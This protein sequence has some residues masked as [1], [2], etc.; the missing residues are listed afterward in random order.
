MSYIFE[1]YQKNYTDVELI[2]IFNITSSPMV[3]GGSDCD[4]LSFPGNPYDLIIKN[5]R[6]MWHTKLNMYGWLIF[7]YPSKLMTITGYRIWAP[8]GCCTLQN[9]YLKGS[10]DG[11][12]WNQIAYVNSNTPIENRGK[13]AT[14]KVP[15]STYRMYKIEEEQSSFGS[16]CGTWFGLRKVDF[17]QIKSKK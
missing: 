10:N 16:N 6:S 9:H 4:G 2:K 12:D 5:P 14:Y 11:V 17:S 1:S 8:N 13:W 7:E 15:E 3:E